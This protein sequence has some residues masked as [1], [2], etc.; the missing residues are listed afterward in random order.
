MP[1]T[2]STALSGLRANSNA[3][4]SVGNNIANANTTAYKSSSLNFADVYHDAASAKINGAGL[5][6][7]IGGG[8]NTVGSSTD[9]S[10]GTFE[11]SG[12]ALHAGIQ[13]NGFFMVK[14]SD[15]VQSYT[16]AGVFSLSRDGYLEVPGGQRLQ[17]YQAVDGEIPV[18]AQLNDLRASL[19]EFAAPI[20]TDSATFRMNLSAKDAV[21]TSFHSSVQIFDSLGISHTLDLTYAKTGN[22]A[23]TVTA[24]V[25]GNASQLD[26]DGGGGQASANMTFDSDGQMTAPATLSVIA[27]QTQLNGATL[28]EIMVGLYNV[29]PDGTQGAS[30][31]TNF[32]AKSA[33]AST[34]QNGYASG[35]LAG[36]AFSPEG[37]GEMIAV[38]SNGQT[39]VVGQLALATFNSQEGL[40]RLGDNLFSET[41]TSGA[42]SVGAPATG[43][44]GSVVGGVLEK[45]NVDIATE[46]TNLI[47]AQR[48]FQANSRVITTINQTLQ[49]VIQII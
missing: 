45:S 13:G 19:G 2:F 32:D 30:V 4:G 36:L 48:G 14:G 16:R 41:N 44:R 20:A 9:F 1:L 18:D 26:A 35:T 39:R 6:L 23:Y 10:Q 15:G 46:F 49:D 3:L 29:N 7:Q 24:T 25:D 40:R 42:P 38:Y 37:S 22:G 12:S 28:P 5:V 43:R 47:V 33:V 17:G 31:I 8:V 34:E 11:D 21:G 27:D